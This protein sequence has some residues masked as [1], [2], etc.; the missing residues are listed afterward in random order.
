MG[1]MLSVMVF[2]VGVV[3]ALSRIRHFECGLL[4]VSNPRRDSMLLN[5]RPKRDSWKED[6]KNEFESD[7]ITDIARSQELHL[8]NLQRQHL[9]LQ[10]NLKSGPGQAGSDCPGPA[11][12]TQAAISPPLTT[13]VVRR[14]ET[15]EL[16]NCEELDRT[17]TDE[18][19][20][21]VE[22]ALPKR[23]VDRWEANVERARAGESPIKTTVRDDVGGEEEEPTSSS[24][25]ESSAKK[26]SARPEE[27]D[28]AR[29]F[30]K[31]EKGSDAPTQ[32]E[33]FW[34]RDFAGSSGVPLAR[35][36]TPWNSRW[37][38][39]DYFASP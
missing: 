4:L 33:A 19:V 20:K 14:N 17:F 28:V 12:D 24:D 18:N 16:K 27:G 8:L 5:F 10:L 3:E 9:K 13:K 35:S 32:S 15:S 22:E 23:S 31:T 11:V 37:G 6:K 30:C 7:E 34:V 1:L 36:E 26:L 21:Q 25:K 2:C 38:P 29:P 39:D